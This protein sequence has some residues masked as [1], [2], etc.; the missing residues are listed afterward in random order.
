[1]KPLAPGIL[2]LAVA[3]CGTIGR[4][5]RLADRPCNAVGPW[6]DR[7]PVEICLG[8][9]LA[10]PSALG[11]S[12]GLCAAGTAVACTQDDTCGPRERCRCGR[13]RVLRCRASAECREGEACIVALGRCAR[14]CD[15]AIPA[16]CPAGL[17]CSL[18]GCVATCRDDG[19][20]SF[21]EACFA[22]TGRC[23]ATPCATDAECG[24]GR[25]C[26]L[27]TVGVDVLAPEPAAEDGRPFV[28]AEVRRDGRSVLQRFAWDSP[29]RLVAESAGPLLG[30]EAPWEAERVGA[31]ALVRDDDRWL[32]FYAGGVEAGIG[33][34]ESEASG[35][36][37][38]VADEPV[39]DPVLPWEDGRVGAPAAV[40]DGDG[41]LLLFYEGA[42]GAGIGA[43]RGS[44]VGGF[45]RFGEA[46]LLVPQDL[47][48]EDRWSELDRIAEP[49]VPFGES[50]ATLALL[51]AGHGLLAT[52]GAPAPDATADWSLGL[53]LVE[54][55]ATGLSWTADP[56]GPVLAGRTGVGEAGERDERSPGLLRTD[57]GWWL[58]Y[59]ETDA[60]G[61]R[62]IRA[63]TCP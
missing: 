6:T 15:P 3:S 49:E 23:T 56:F 14:P 19:S 59:E 11:E 36:F 43:A 54:P 13:C 48:V 18:G 16:S 25:R 61:G 52:G 20:C 21:G 51:A 4:D 42:G 28:V 12:G 1:M 46:P 10:L 63:A 22:R 53:V 57:T 34:A 27:Q 62:R 8:S 45:E 2:L 5:D 17:G 50:T 33:L 9:S 47:A 40:A 35:A 24:T 38:R 39:L 7:G 32:L 31:P 58:L 30:P 44:V 26:D 37:S 41:T 29:A 55:S 60:A